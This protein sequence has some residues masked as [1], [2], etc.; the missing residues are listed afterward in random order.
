MSAMLS[1]QPAA[2]KVFGS[3]PKN[4]LPEYLTHIGWTGSIPELE[5]VLTT[6]CAPIDSIQIDLTV[7]NMISPRL[8]IEFFSDTSSQKDPGRHLLLN[9]F[10][11]SGLCTPEKRDILFAW[12]GDS[13]EV[14][15]G[16]SWPSR[17]I[18]WLDLKLVYLP[19][20]PLEAK[21]YLGFSPRFSLF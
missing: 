18:R 6:F 15:S 11:E 19:N 20:Q 8:G 16:Q 9:Q 14:F 17:L 3:I 5:T 2:L 10:V 12:P 1:R 21:G 7:G 13:R 4:Q